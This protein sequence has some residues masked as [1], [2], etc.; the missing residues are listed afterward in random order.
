MNAEK[1][2]GEGDAPDVILGGSSSKDGRGLALL[3]EAKSKK[4]SFK[5]LLIEKYWDWMD[6]FLFL[7]FTSNIM[8]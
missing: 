3:N 4:R 2:I 1:E 5:I 8:Q 7:L 6:S